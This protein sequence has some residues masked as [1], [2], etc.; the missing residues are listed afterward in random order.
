MRRLKRTALTLLVI[1]ALPG[2]IT[3][4]IS[5]YY[6]DTVKH[7]II[8]E[9]NK[10]LNTEIVV[11]NV[12]RDI[13]FSVFRDFPY[14]SVTFYNVAIMDAV[15]PPKKKGKLLQA[16]SVSLQFNLWDIIFG[17]YVIKKIA[18]N[19][20]R[21]K[22]KR[23]KDRT[24]NYHFWKPSA[25]SADTQFS[26]G[27][28][29]VLLRRVSIQYVDYRLKHDF[30]VFAGD[31]V[32]RGKF[33]DD[34]F[35]MNIDGD[36]YV[37]QIRIDRD[38]YVANRAADLDVTLYVNNKDDYLEFRE[39]WVNIGKMKL[40]LLGKISWAEADTWL[41]LAIE[42]RNMK[43]QSFIN[44]LPTRYRSAFDGY[45]CR[46]DFTFMANIKGYTGDNSRPLFTTTLSLNNGEIERIANDIT[47]N[48][49]S[50]SA[51]YTNGKKHASETSVLR[52]SGFNAALNDG[53]ISGE[54]GISNFDRPLLDLKLTADLG[55][56]DVFLFMKADTVESASG[57]IKMNTT[58][59][60]VLESAGNFTVRDFINS[61][62]SGTL[63]IVDAEIMLKGLQQKFASV[64]GS[65][66]FN[67]NDI[68]SR[69]FSGSYMSSDFLLKGNFRNILPYLFLDNQNLLIDATVESQHIHMGELLES[70][71]A[72][73]KKDTTYRIRFPDNIQLDL[74][75][76]VHNMTFN[77]FSA[78]QIGGKITL[79]NKQ[80]I[81]KDISLQAMNGRIGFTGLIDGSNPGKLLISCDAVINKVDVQRLFREMGNFGQ[82]SL[83]DK[84][85][86]GVLSATV[87][88]ASIWS[89]D[90]RVEKPTIYG[91][92][93]ISIENGELIEYE[94]LNGLSKYLK[95][96]D[97][98]HVKFQ[99]LKNTISIEHQ[100]IT[101]PEME[102]NSSAINFKMNG[103]HG[104]D[105]T[106]D[107]H[108]SVLISQL[109]KGSKPVTQAGDIGV[110]EDD[111]LH[112]EKYF[113]RITGTVDN[114]IYH[115]LDKEGMKANIKTN[116][117][118]EKETLKEI[119]NREFGWFKKDS[120]I[121]KDP[122]DKPKDKYDF[123]VIWDEDEEEKKELP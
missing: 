64:N 107:Y 44:E 19:E 104:F 17:R 71:S 51:S 111:G 47:L 25:D 63:D 57:R 59:K 31:V 102:I 79:K 83:E 55:L 78:S 89:D 7:I 61:T 116:I 93:N 85:I 53:N 65:F 11:E 118:K 10:R 37:W 16:Q 94:P 98:S 32:F 67:N 114:P 110:I 88:F 60:G 112:K 68:E 40:G 56:K 34:D 20:A 18:I 86:K 84:N 123:N 119:L 115:T 21:I 77:K 45:N 9:L 4:F 120:T 101:I 76:K 39:A 52:I 100:M 54:A 50:F 48:R 6:E 27:L 70:S 23:Y 5:W 36:M 38:V 74:D 109:G 82:K 41:D 35:R 30:K 96:R 66:V 122:R 42:G 87:Q 92:A 24:D 117:K 97:L 95:N 72:P 49:V 33:S 81:A 99:T 90:L 106:I 29:K 1:L 13:A 121:N 2:L 12:E 62:S 80:L 58:I 113:F 14:A 46:G 28:Q 69:N 15:S 75:L 91:K 26:L 3:L 43:L 103:T 105:Q 73:G 22:I 108:L 8:D